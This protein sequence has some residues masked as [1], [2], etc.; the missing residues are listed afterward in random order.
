[1]RRKKLKLSAVLQLGIG[2]TGLQAQYGVNATENIASGN[3]G[4]R[5]IR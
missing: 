2:L 3:G 1:M 5:A 4:L